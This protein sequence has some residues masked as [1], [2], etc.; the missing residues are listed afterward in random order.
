MPVGVCLAKGQR[1][2]LVSPNGLRISPLAAEHGPA[3]VRYFR[4]SWYR[5]WIGDFEADGLLARLQTYDSCLEE[6]ENRSQ[7][8]CQAVDAVHQQT[9]T[10]SSVYDMVLPSGWL[11]RLCDSCAETMRSMVEFADRPAMMPGAAAGRVVSVEER[12]ALAARFQPA[13]AAQ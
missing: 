9:C 3:P 8:L 12:E 6:F 1:M 4:L 11:V 13:P 2:E 10:N 7:I 5:S